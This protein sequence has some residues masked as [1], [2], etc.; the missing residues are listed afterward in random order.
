VV[1]WKGLGSWADS[2]ELLRCGGSN[3]AAL[4]SGGLTGGGKGHLRR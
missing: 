1:V 3:N 4:V 2:W